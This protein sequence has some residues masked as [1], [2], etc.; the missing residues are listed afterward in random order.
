[1]RCVHISTANRYEI[2]VFN[3]G[4]VLGFLFTLVGQQKLPSGRD[5]AGDRPAGRHFSRGLREGRG[6]AAGRREATDL[7]GEG[8]FV[9]V[10]DASVGQTGFA[11]ARAGVRRRAG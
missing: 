2:H 4:L 6:G 3:S 1:M 8:A 10:A 9:H 5:E 11:A 7:G